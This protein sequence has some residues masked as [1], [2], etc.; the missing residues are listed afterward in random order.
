MKL[1]FIIPAYNAS[2]T[3]VR[4]LDSIYSHSLK[5]DDFEVIVV[6]D[7]STDDTLSILRDYANTHS[8]MQVLHQEKNHRQGAARNRGLQKAIG[9]YVMFVDSDDR[10]EIGV[11]EAIVYAMQKSVDILVCDY[12]WLTN[13]N[14]TRRQMPQ[15]IEG[16]IFS[17]HEFLETLYDVVFNTCPINYL[18]KRSFL[19]KANHPFIEDRRME[20]IDWIEKNI[21]EASS[22]CYLSVPIYTVIG[23]PESTTHT[24]NVGTIS[25]WLHFSHRR[26]DF[27]ELYKN[28]LPKF[29]KKVI[30]D[31]PRFVIRNTRLR[32]LSN[33]SS[34]Q[35]YSI[36][37]NIGKESLQ[38]LQRYSWPIQARLF[39]NYPRLE[40]IIIAVLHPISKISRIIV[41]KF[42]KLCKN[43]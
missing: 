40:L 14:L 12:N 29:Y 18:W 21:I 39:I 5:T 30:D 16:K 36:Y 23:H 6:D 35:V 34:T 11:N 20:D 2:S 37:Q 38:T 13:G 9:E 17:S 27:A 42:R 15:K 7:C 1:S 4:T 19:Q 26:Y 31:N 41:R 24:T 28:M 33:F 25:D 32:M 22:I 10:V 3:V 8:N 43:F